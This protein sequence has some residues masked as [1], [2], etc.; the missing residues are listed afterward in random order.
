MWKN[1]EDNKDLVNVLNYASAFTSGTSTIEDDGLEDAR[2]NGLIVD[3]GNDVF[4]VTAID[5]TTGVITA[6]KLTYTA[7]SNN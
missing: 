3:S 4:L 6:I 1:Y 2:K 7:P 5:A